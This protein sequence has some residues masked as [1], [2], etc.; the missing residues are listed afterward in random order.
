M[1]SLS[2]TGG[3]TLTDQIGLPGFDIPPPVPSRTS[4]TAE[5][6]LRDKQ[7][8]L[9]SDSSELVYWIFTH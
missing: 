6:A 3:E 2:L 4:H 7:V 8:S 9:H 1:V 5:D